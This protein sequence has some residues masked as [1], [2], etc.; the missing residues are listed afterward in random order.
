MPYLHG[1]VTE[2]KDGSSVAGSFAVHPF[3][4]IQVLFPLAIL[5]PLWLWTQKSA[6]SLIF[7]G[8]ISVLLLFADAILI[9]AAKRLR[10]KEEKDIVQFLFGLFPDAGPASDMHS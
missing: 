3:N 7:L 9:G 6:R 4:R 5:I 2:T 8:M 1:E 10:P